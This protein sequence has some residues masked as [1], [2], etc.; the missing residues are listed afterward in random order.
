MR[1]VFGDLVVAVHPNT[2][3][4]MAMKGECIGDEIDQR[5]TE[6][7]PVSRA[8]RPRFDLLVRF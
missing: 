2:E 3:L 5:Q 8:L 1:V 4:S 6:E 7:V